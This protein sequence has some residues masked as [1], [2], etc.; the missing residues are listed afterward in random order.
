[1]IRFLND[2]ERSAATSARRKWNFLTSLLFSRGRLAR[3][4]LS[5]TTFRFL[6]EHG[7]HVTPVHFY[8]P[9]PDFR[10]LENQDDLW[11]QP[12]VCPGIDFNTNE[13]RSLLSDVF[14]HYAATE[15]DFAKVA[16]ETQFHTENAFFGYIS[17]VA[18]HSIV[19]K[20]KPRRV[21]EVGVGNS[22]LVIGE[23]LNRNRSVGNECE[24]IGIDP[25][26]PDY[27]RCV[28]FPIVLINKR[29][30]EVG[31]EYFESLG[32]NDILSID[33]SHAV[34]TG[35]DVTFLYLNIL[36]R[37]AP[38]VLVHIHDIFLPYEY[39]KDWLAKRFFW[40]EQYLL[41]S[42]L[43]HS[44]AFSILWAQRYI[45]ASFPQ[46]YTKAFRRTSFE[47][48]HDSYCFWIRRR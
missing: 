10:E 38:G 40:N 33:T 39:P 42:M 35:G 15:C 23:A 4:L 20:Y 17:G 22:S 9:V 48:N 46:E 36:P 31:L 7:V 11:S 13:Q 27:L 41:H 30:Q 32:E 6:Q 24:F 34:R 1:M 5:T 12:H 19:R 14:A 37:L 2:M 45:E 3:I 8:S 18:M 21:I 44:R 16:S 28:K 25:Y 26:A 29:V 47:D 43:A